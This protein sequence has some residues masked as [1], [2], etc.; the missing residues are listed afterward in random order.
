MTTPSKKE[1]IDIIINEI[2]SEQDFD[3]YNHLIYRLMGDDTF[4]N[5][6]ENLS[7]IIE[8]EI[9]DKILSFQKKE[10]DTP[11]K[12]AFIERIKDL[13][14]IKDCFIIVND[15]MSFTLTYNGYVTDANNFKSGDILL[16]RIIETETGSEDSE[17]LF[18]KNEIDRVIG[19]VI[20]EIIS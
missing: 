9:C 14:N 20:D 17:T 8:N 1:R 3:T 11:S 18:S 10:I 2:N 19:M 7:D 12:Q 5:L 13:L 6:V 15:K 16:T 4:K